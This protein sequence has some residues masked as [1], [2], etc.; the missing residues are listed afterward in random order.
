MQ[1]YL[2]ISCPYNPQHIILPDR[3]IFHLSNECKDSIA[4]KN[5]QNNIQQDFLKIF[6]GQLSFQLNK[7]ELEI[8]NNLLTQVNSS[9]TDIQFE[10]SISKINEENQIQTQKQM[11]KQLIDQFKNLNLSY[12]NQKL[13]KQQN[14]LNQDEDM[15]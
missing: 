8:N 3:L 12:Q 2:H 13:I 14:N 1:Q 11:D 6:R 15:N 7:E 9:N 4:Y 5:E 10:K